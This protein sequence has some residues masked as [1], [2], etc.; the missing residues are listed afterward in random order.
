M[1]P[2][3]LHVRRRAGHG[4]GCRGS[5]AAG[6][7]PPPPPSLRPLLPSPQRCPR[8]HLLVPRC[9]PTRRAAR[10]RWPGRHRHRRRPPPAHPHR[11][12]GH[13]HPRRRLAQRRR[14]PTLPPVAAAAAPPLPPS[15]PPPEK[16]SFLASLPHGDVPVRPA[17]RRVGRSPHL[18]RTASDD[19]GEVTAN[20]RMRVGLV[21]KLVRSVEQCAPHYLNSGTVLEHAQGSTASH[22]SASQPTCGGSAAA[23]GAASLRWKGDWRRQV[24]TALHCACGRIRVAC[25]AA[26]S[27][28][29]RSGS[30]SAHR[31]SARRNRS[32]CA[33]SM[34]DCRAD[35]AAR[36]GNGSSMRQSHT[37]CGST[38][39]HGDDDTRGT[40]LEPQLP[41]A[42]GGLSRTQPAG[43]YNSCT[44]R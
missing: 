36:R 17:R 10:R 31:R 40:G 1:R 24:P 38:C 39:T 19:A 5:R 14:R 22:K 4:T 21:S 20:Q 41:R 42:S 9:R 23:H 3:P 15:G 35:L 43:A 18:D 11:R 8:H 2:S 37:L 33:R 6:E 44:Q 25:C 26:D 32:G 7:P 13:C 29:A 30:N 27:G 12:P 28:E 34:A 16:K